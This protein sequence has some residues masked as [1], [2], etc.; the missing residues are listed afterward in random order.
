MLCTDTKYGKIGIGIC[1]DLR[2]AKLG[3]LMAE[4]GC[5][6]L[7]YPAAYRAPEEHWELMLRARAIDNQVCSLVCSGSS[8]LPPARAT[9]VF[10][11]SGVRSW[12]WYCPKPLL[13]WLGTLHGSEPLGGSSGD[14]TLRSR[15]CVP[16]H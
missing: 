7:L 4:A 6:L 16:A 13:S 14:L 2:F 10:V 11:T 1:Y 15:H 12:H 9:H 5:K 3:M 8:C